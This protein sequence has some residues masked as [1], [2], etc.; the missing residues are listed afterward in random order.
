LGIVP[1]TPC[2]LSV[3]VIVFNPGGN[4]LKS[5]MVLCDPAQKSASDGVKL[6]DIIVEEIGKQAKLSRFR[7]KEIE[8]SEPIQAEGY[9]AAT[10]SMLG[11]PDAKRSRLWTR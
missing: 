3:H 5:E 1:H 7:G 11:W 4:S 2:D 6:I 8:Q 10:A 9:A